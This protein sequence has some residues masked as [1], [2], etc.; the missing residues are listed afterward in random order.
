[1]I[2][3]TIFNEFMHEQTEDAIEKVYPACIH[4]AL[5]DF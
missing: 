4:N 3:V 2:K 1:M 5:K